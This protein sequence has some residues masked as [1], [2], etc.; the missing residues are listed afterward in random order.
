MAQ[1]LIDID[2]GARRLWGRYPVKVHHR[3]HE[4]AMFDDDCLEKL[5]DTVPSQ[6]IHHSVAKSDRSPSEFGYCDKGSLSGKEV[7]EAVKKGR[8]WVNLMK[9]QA[10]GG[11]YAALL[12]RIYGELSQKVPHF[13]SI[14]RSLGLLISSPRALVYYHADLPSQCL[15]QIRGK[16]RLWVYPNDDPFLE[17][18]QL[19]NLARGV[20]EEVMPYQ[21]WFDSYATC[22]LLEPG[23]M[24]HW[25]L[26]SPHRV[27]N[28]DC[29]NVSL[30]TGHWTSET[31]RC[32]AVNYANGLLRSRFG[33]RPRSRATAGPV[34]WAK[35]GFALSWRRLGLEK[36]DRF[37]RSYAYKLDLDSEFGVKPI[38]AETAEI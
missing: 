22:A 18:S 25:P 35:A 5:I 36:R 9:L 1:A 7:L 3:L 4:L 16:K 38:G 19:E 12:D 37:K 13:K 14:R 11:P 27:E 21:A 10:Q 28:L 8:L 31:R 17:R 24:L 26:N 2:E 33:W 20:Q 15:W 30:T 32:F 23:D 29:L 6:M 34:F